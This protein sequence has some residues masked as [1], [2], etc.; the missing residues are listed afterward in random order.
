MENILH[1][2]CEDVQSIIST[3]NC[4][5]DQARSLAFFLSPIFMRFATFSLP[6]LLS[7]SFR[8]LLLTGVLL[9][10]PKHIHET[11]TLSKELSVLT[12][13]K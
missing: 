5:E 9:A 7:L 11:S 4:F 12:M 3:D 1:F 6:R 10:P 2:V 13:I 8:C